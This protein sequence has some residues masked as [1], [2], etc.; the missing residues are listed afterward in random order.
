MHGQRGQDRIVIRPKR[1]QVNPA[2]GRPAI[3]RPTQ[4][5][6]FLRST[7]APRPTEDSTFESTSQLPFSQSNQQNAVPELQQGAGLENSSPAVQSAPTGRPA[8]TTV[9]SGSGQETAST[10]DRSE[11]PP[12]RRPQVST[13]S[14]D[15]NELPIVLDT[16]EGSRP[17]EGRPTSESRPT[18]RPSS[19]TESTTVSSRVNDKFN[20]LSRDQE[21]AFNKKLEDAPKVLLISNVPATILSDFNSNGGQ[22]QN[23]VDDNDEIV[24]VDIDKDVFE[25]D[26]IP[27]QASSADI[28][29]V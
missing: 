13:P 5:P 25:T 22:L 10:S 8:G 6:P 7:I 11:A 16:S 24:V 14:D 17:T 28:V 15:S 9:A 18:A 29:Q 21:D 26:L 3:P 27:G 23:V 19:T 4:V 12:T 20:S 1:P 2:S